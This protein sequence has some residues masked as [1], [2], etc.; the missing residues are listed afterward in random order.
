MRAA[1]CGLRY[2][3]GAL[4]STFYILRY[5]VCVLCSAFY[6]LRSTFYVLRSTGYGLRSTFYL[7][8]STLYRL[9]SAFYFLRSTFYLIRT[10]YCG[11]LLLLRIHAG[12]SGCWAC[13]PGGCVGQAT[14]DMVPPGAG[15]TTGGSTHYALGPWRAV[16]EAVHGGLP[17]TGAGEGPVTDVLADR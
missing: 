11:L 8:H 15:L 10:T 14:P 9:Q 5:A 16:D 4:R 2:A 3:F 13:V 17:G 6:G 12:S 7:L 1:C